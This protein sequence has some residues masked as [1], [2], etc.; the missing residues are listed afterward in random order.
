ML[1]SVSFLIRQLNA[2]TFNVITGKGVFISA[3]SMF[4]FCDLISDT[5]ISM[6]MFFDFS[7][8]SFF[9]LNRYFLVYQFL[10]YHF[11]SIIFYFSIYLCA[12]FLVITLKI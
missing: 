3:I 12:I 2:F 4:I 11:N 8:L 5:Q 7:I 6:F 10:V 9:T 1:A